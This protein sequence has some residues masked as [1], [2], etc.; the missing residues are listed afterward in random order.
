[1]GFFSRLNE[2]FGGTTRGV[3]GF[4]PAVPGPFDRPPEEPVELGDDIP[5]ELREDELPRD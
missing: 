3:A 4:R 5:W 1:M 2:M